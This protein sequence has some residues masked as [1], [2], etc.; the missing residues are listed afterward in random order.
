MP[1][2]Y[3]TAFGVIVLFCQ[4]ASAQSLYNKNE[5][6][7]HLGA[8]FYQGDLTANPGSSLAVPNF[9]GELY[10]SRLFNSYL[11]ARFNIMAGS[12][13]GDDGL[14]HD[15]TKAYMQQ[16]LFRFSTPLVE[17]SL[18]AG[19]N[20]FGNNYGNAVQR[21]SP[22]V[23]AG[24]GAAYIDVNRDWSRMDTSFVHANPA[25][26]T[27]LVIDATQSTSR[28]IPVIPVAVGLKYALTQRVSLVAEGK[29]R[30]GF[31]DYIDGFSYAAN[32][33]HNDSYFTVMVGV[34]Y[35]F[36][37]AGGFAKKTGGIGC[38]RF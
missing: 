22:Y 20:F 17:A 8:G 15:E 31:S 3:I 24:I 4:T 26:F 9:A 36:G 33:D 19:Y 38:P 7:I 37:K 10:Y 13:H 28:I 14:N 32:P 2:R 34:A 21:F 5:V 11:F 18:M 23:M 29:Y 16:R 12:L 35:N 1:L 6:G 27:G 25:M 30:F